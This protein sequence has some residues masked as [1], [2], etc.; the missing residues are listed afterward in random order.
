MPRFDSPLFT[1]L[2]AVPRY[3]QLTLSQ[4]ASRD[5]LEALRRTRLHKTLQ[6]AM[7]IPFYAERFGSLPSV[8]ELEKLPILQR[9]DLAQ[10]TRSVL[11]SSPPGARMI[12]VKTSGTTGQSVDVLFDRS[13][14]SGR[15]AA[16]AR[17]LVENGWLP[18]HRTA[19]ALGLRPDPPSPDSILSS[20]RVIM[21][22][23]FMS[24]TEDFGKQIAWMRRM[25]PH[26]IYTLPSNLDALLMV[27]GKEDPR[28]PA[29]RKIFLGGE[30][31][32][33][34]LRARTRQILGVDIVD[35]YGTTEF[36]PAWQCPDG[37]YHLNTEHL[38]VELL[39]DDGAQARPGELGRVV[40]TTLEN[41]LAPLIRYEIGD[42]AMAVEGS[43]SCGRTLPLIG[44]V[45]G[46]SINLFRL[47]NGELYLPWRIYDFLEGLDD[48]RQ[49]QLVQ[50]ALDHFVIKFV[51]D[52]PLAP[53][54]EAAIKKRIADGIGGGV[55][56]EL[57]RVDEIPRTRRG[58]F[59]AALCEIAPIE[60]TELPSGVQ[61]TGS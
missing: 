45:V 16:R 26:F 34:S 43:C 30:V 9:A 10:I 50:R 13:H 37:N 39:D 3:A 29:L 33:D 57:E 4:Y 61:V 24:H 48:L 56:V 23:Q 1:L 47:K 27:L 46:R 52:E 35:N 58:K 60:T 17:Y 19:W 5:R 20:S 55:T 11:S 18:I 42:Y 38:I 22:S 6:A 32:D 12:K 28:L 14:Q 59:M 54:V 31:L 49:L 53:E 51:R 7:R 21:G 44:K 36:F 25:N 15:H 2:E 8:A 40:V 41:Y